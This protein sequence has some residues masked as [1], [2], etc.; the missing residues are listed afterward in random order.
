MYKIEWRGNSNTNKSSRS[1][2]TPIAIVNHITGGTASSADSWFR[3]SRNNVSSAHFLVTKEG[4]IKQYVKIEDKAWANGLTSDIKHATS[5]LVKEKYP[6]TRDVNGYT[7]SIENENV[8]GKLTEKQFSALIWLHQ[9]IREY[10][11]EKYGYKIPFNRKHILGHFEIDNKRK[12]FCPGK[13]FPWNRLMEELNMS[14]KIN[15][16]GKQIE[17]EDYKKINDK[18][19]ISIREIFEKIGLNVKWTKDKGI[20]IELK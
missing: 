6:E 7:I 4:K 16:L 3:S 2:K 20:E 15:F 14:L 1:G 5:T 12:A 9:Y 13:Y 18:N 8:D 19:Y 11:K 17:L 10:V